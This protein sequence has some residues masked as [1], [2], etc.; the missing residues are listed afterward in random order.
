MP[1]A[2]ADVE[3][4]GDLSLGEWSPRRSRFLATVPACVSGDARESY[5][6]SVS[7][8]ADDGFAMRN[9]IG[10]EIA[11]RVRWYARGDRGRRENLRPGEPS[12][13]AYR[14][15]SRTECEAGEAPGLEVRARE[16][17]VDRAAPGR[18]RDVLVLTVSAV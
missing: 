8:Q 5:R 6:V 4:G 16:R 10:D 15:Q 18:Y 3:L 13:R 17:D 2:P 12:R 1:A 14:F 9:D 11:Y 7:G